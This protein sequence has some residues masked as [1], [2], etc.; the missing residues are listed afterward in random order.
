MEDQDEI[1]FENNELYETDNEKEIKQKPKEKNN[2]SFSWKNVIL[3]F[4][5][6][7]LI[8]RLSILLFTIIALLAVIVD[9]VLLIIYT[10][11]VP[12]T[13]LSKISFYANIGFRFINYF[14]NRIIFS[15]FIIFFEIDFAPLMRPFLFAR[16]F[17]TK[18]ILQIL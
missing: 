17:I 9:Q 10:Q 8:I 13:L 11:P 16:L 4:G 1:K 5:I 2:N 7:Q 14:K 18:G 3:Y 12:N 6:I 15:A